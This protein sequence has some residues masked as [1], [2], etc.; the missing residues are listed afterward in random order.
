V[1]VVGSLVVVFGVVVFD[2]ASDLVGFWTG[3]VLRSGVVEV[4][5]AVFRFG[6]AGV[7]FRRGLLA[8]W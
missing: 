1:A 2:R 6:V 4:V 3:L 8:L 7:W 5:M